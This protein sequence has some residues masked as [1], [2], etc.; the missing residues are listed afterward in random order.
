MQKIS[1]VSLPFA[2]MRKIRGAII[3][4]KAGRGQGGDYLWFKGV[5]V[6]DRVKK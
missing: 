1:V 6:A 2:R 4:V 5:R 3:A